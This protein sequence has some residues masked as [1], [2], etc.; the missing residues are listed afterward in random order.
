[1]ILYLGTSSLVK[2]YID[3]VYSDTIRE[4]IKLAEIVATCRIAYTETVSALENRLKNREIS[5]H[6]YDTVIKGFTEDWKKYAVVDF[7]EVDAGQLMRKYGIKRFSAMHLSS[8]L[9]LKKAEAGISIYFSSVD[10]RL[11]KAAAK[12]GL[13]IVTLT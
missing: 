9:L 5:R 3:E 12:E 10:E 8:A 1:L 2:F 6:D 7:D 11:N 4:W 13:R